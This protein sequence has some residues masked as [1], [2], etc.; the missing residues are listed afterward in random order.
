MPLEYESV[1]YKELNVYTPKK[2]IDPTK[3]EIKIKHS[4]HFPGVRWL[5]LS[6]LSAGGPGSIP[7]QGTRF[8]RLQQ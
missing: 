2:N 1:A 3:L 8:Y 5:R 4:R 6:A 7:G